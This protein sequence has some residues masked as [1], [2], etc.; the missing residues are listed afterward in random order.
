VRHKKIRLANLSREEMEEYRYLY[1][2]ADMST[3]FHNIN[4]LIA[5]NNT[6]INLTLKF[7]VLWGEGKIIAMMPYFS[8]QK[9]LDLSMSSIPYGGYG[10][11]LYK[12]ENKEKITTY[13][14]NKKFSTL[15]TLLNSYKDPF[16][17]ELSY[18][19]KEKHSTWV[20]NTAI[21]YE[22]IFQNLHPKTRNQIR[23]SNKSDVV[24]KDIESIQEVE[25]V[26]NL[27]KK[28]VIKHTIKKPYS[29]KLFYELF[30][31]NQK[32]NNIQIKLAVFNN[33]TI[34][35]SIFLK[36]KKQVFYW[37]N[38]SDREHSKLN[39]TNGILNSVLESSSRESGIKEL[40][41]GAV[42]YGNCGLNHF[43]KR[44]NASEQE[45]YSYSS[46]LYRLAKGLV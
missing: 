6:R 38:A 32:D 14:N 1:E 41:L 12:I 15:L 28:L 17:N 36:N 27:Y 7:Y 20:I 8:H 24:I 45:Y 29:D 19:G 9:S 42:P 23:K 18:L 2:T 16:Y 4:F 3:P 46:S 30:L 13:L 33:Q 11:F 25:S 10:G 35:Y 21:N 39:A 5:L 22:N 37:M 34:A 43:K 44:W 26:V 31:A 40:N